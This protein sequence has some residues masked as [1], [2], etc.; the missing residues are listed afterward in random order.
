MKTGI[1]FVLVL[2]TIAL[3]GCYH[4]KYVYEYADGTRIESTAPLDPRIEITGL[5]AADVD[6]NSFSGTWRGNNLK[7]ARDRQNITLS[8]VSDDGRR[9]SGTC[10]M[11]RE[12]SGQLVE[13]AF[14]IKRDSGVL[15]FERTNET[16]GAVTLTFDPAFVAAV[17]ELTGET[18]S[19]N[20][21]L[22][23]FQN[24]M[25]LSYV[26]AVKDSRLK[27]SL[28][29]LFEL[30]NNGVSAEYIT[31]IRQAYDFTPKQIINLTRNGISR[32][33]AVAI[34]DAGYQLSDEQLVNLTRNGIG[35]DFA[36]DMK[37]AGYG[38]VDDLIKL[39]RNGV[40]RTYARAMLDAGY[41]F[42]ADDLVDLTRNG[43]GSDYAR[44]IR[45]SGYNATASDLIALNRNGVSSQFVAA[46]HEP[47]K[48]N[49]SV[50]AIVDLN[51]RG[52]DAA[53]VKK[54]RGM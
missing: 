37:A 29:E 40:G 8:L 51:R 45:Q 6:G 27:P 19:A 42:S 24:W 41:K 3:I 5:E 18:P 22:R 32:D 49:L 48:P 36:R 15:K 28:D 2:A 20:E 23:L 44:R 34:R 38:S 46:L 25:P 39:S 54:I 17:T 1:A 13:G 11:T 16:G 30:R 4:T 14:E 52:V 53:T 21:K 7:L 43:V 9:R 31:T 10:I 26:R 50:D 33:Y 12:I 47:N 35:R